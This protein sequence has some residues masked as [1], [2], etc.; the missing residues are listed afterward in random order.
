MEEIRIRPGQ[1]AQ[2]WRDLVASRELLA[3]LVWRDISVRYK[4]TLLGVAWAVLQPLT[5]LIIMTFV[6]GRLAGLPPEGSATYGGMVLAGMLPWQLFATT[7]SSCG[8][9]MVSNA[10]LVAKIYFPRI[11]APLAGTATGLVDFLLAGLLLIPLGWWLGLSVGTGV[12]LLPFFILLACVTALG[13]GLLIA[14]LNVKY[15][16][17]RFVVPFLIQMGMYASPVAYSASLVREKTGPVIALLYSCNPMVAVIDG[18][19]WALT[20][21]PP[22]PLSAL[23]AGCVVAVVFLFVGWSYFRRVEREFADVI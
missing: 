18:F 12:L 10:N 19:R 6:F 21:A 1:R 9:S 5:A 23:A 4:Q 22:P 8:Q 20:G 17:F 2:Y 16:D 14:A 11:L 13:P 15:R 3:I 7:L